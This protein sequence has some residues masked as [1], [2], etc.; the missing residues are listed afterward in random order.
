MRRQSCLRGSNVTIA[1]EAVEALAGLG[2]SSD[3]ASSSSSD[4][5]DVDRSLARSCLGPDAKKALE[6]K[7]ERRRFEKQ[8]E[9]RQSRV[10]FDNAALDQQQVEDIQDIL[11]NWEEKEKEASSQSKLGGIRPSLLPPLNSAFP[12]SPRGDF[13]MTL[14]GGSE[15]PSM[16]Q[17]PST[18]GSAFG[19][20]VAARPSIMTGAGHHGQRPSTLNLKRES[21]LHFQKSS[22]S[23]RL[24]GPIA[25]CSIGEHKRAGLTVN[26]DLKAEIKRMRDNLLNSAQSAFGND[27]WEKCGIESDHITKQKLAQH[28]ASGFG[29]LLKKKE[30]EPG[31]FSQDQEDGSAPD[32]PFTKRRSMKRVSTTASS[33]PQRRSVIKAATGKRRTS[34]NPFAM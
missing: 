26:R 33:S 2:S 13:R 15:S 21:S 8:A 19:T 11:Q 28:I 12:P 9:R 24:H 5:E 22:G 32:T 27:V 17:R 29:G 1:T 4:S 31:A 14:F 7:R 18:M 6:E 34:G 23:I 10:N 25:R 30:P 16:M 20:P 3:G